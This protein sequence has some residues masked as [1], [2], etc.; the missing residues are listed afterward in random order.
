M[1]A[2]DP[3][4]IRREEKARAA[5]L[6]EAGVLNPCQKGREA[7]RKRGRGLRRT[8]KGRVLKPRA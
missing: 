8:E 1:A 3:P 6:L 2:S 4:G 5:W 7:I